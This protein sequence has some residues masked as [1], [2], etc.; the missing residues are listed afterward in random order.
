M[1]KF[2]F[3][4]FLAILFCVDLHA[5]TSPLSPASP[6]IQPKTL[7]DE[8]EYYDAVVVLIDPKAG[9]IGL[10]WTNE[11]TQKEEKLSFKVDPDKV[12]VTN[13]LNQILEFPNI[14]EGD[15]VDLVTIKDQNGK[16]KLVEIM[17]FNAVESDA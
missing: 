2:C 4:F 10:S 8:K 16:E 12:D 13:P 9:M 3:L 7:S 1:K 17:D 14:K 11:E 15:H 6:A 5:E